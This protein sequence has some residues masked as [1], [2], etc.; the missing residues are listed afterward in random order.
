V[1]FLVLGLGWFVAVYRRLGWDPLVYFFLRENLQRFAA[2]TY[3]SGRD[4]WFYAPAY[5]AV[6]LPWSLFLPAALSCYVREDLAQQPGL[7][8]S[9]LLSG[10]AGLMLVPLS[11]SR[12]KLDYYLLP[13]LPA[14]SLVLGHYFCEIPWRRFERA[15]ARAAL[16]LLAVGLLLIAV[17]PLRLPVEWLPG[18][19]GRW[20]LTLVAAACAAACALTAVHLRPARSVA[21]L[22][23]SA[24]AVFLVLVVLFLPAFRDAQPNA[25]ILEDVTREL[26]YRPDTS[27]VVC[28]D[29][30]RVQRDLL[31]HA[32][33]AVSERCDLWNPASSRFP[34]L[35]LLNRNEFAS[36][37]AAMKRIRLVRRYEFLPAGV[38]TLRGLLRHSQQEPLFLAANFPSKDPLAKARRRIERQA[39]RA[40]RER[41]NQ[42]RQKGRRP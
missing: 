14:L 24:A 31:F 20:T 30:T 1:C 39:E 15:W 26:R 11:L 9:R 17:G 38:L 37:D 18:P 7:A 41:Q 16:A 28:A 40:E 42:L 29:P 8:G 27:V 36:L 22:A 3:D 12:G 33:V 35:L 19:G 21:A 25:E 23:S 13:L 34:F 6:G 32:R 4:W 2:Q 10:W 5:L